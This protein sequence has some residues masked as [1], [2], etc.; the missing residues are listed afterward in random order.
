MV[1]G[2]FPPDVD[3]VTKLWKWLILIF[4]KRKTYVQKENLHKG[5]KETLPYCQN[6][7]VK[8]SGEMFFGHLRGAYAFLY[9]QTVTSISEE[10]GITGI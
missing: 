4:W 2:E 5:T 10:K 6:K 8:S 7:Q 9:V 1:L 3:R